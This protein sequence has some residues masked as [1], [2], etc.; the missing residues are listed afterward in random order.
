M[1][2]K[3]PEQLISIMALL[4]SFYSF[5]LVE[6]RSKTN[7]EIEISRPIY[8]DHLTNKLP[9]AF[10]EYRNAKNTL[11][12][13]QIFSRHLRQFR[14]DIQY[15]QYAHPHIHRKILHSLSKIDFAISHSTMHPNSP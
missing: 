15:F 9:R 2:D 5:L 12:A 1:I 8:A 4:V 11:R 6:R 10:E 7:Q 14:I 13:N 3:L